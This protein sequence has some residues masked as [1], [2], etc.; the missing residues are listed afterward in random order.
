MPGTYIRKSLRLAASLLLLIIAGYF[1]WT[2]YTGFIAAGYAVVRTLSGDKI[3]KVLLSDGSIIWLKPQSSLSYP[4]KFR[5]AS[6]REVT[7]QGEAL[8][9]VAKKADQPFIVRAN[10]ITTTVLGTSFLI[11]TQTAGTEVAVL[12]GKVKVQVNSADKIVELLPLEKAI[13]APAEGQLTKIAREEVM[14]V[15]E[16]VAGTAYDMNFEN[17]TVSDLAKRISDKFDVKVRVAGNMGR[18]LITAD[19]TDQS[20]QSTLEMVTEVLNA[21]FEV[22]KEEVVLSGQN[23]Q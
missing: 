3:S 10:D 1:S 20:L 22:T 17:A 6:F 7:I 12:T 15:A 11:K 14:P 4:R 19:F 5:E 16:L 23:C 2:A 21:T 8:F 9:E 18:C 13:Y